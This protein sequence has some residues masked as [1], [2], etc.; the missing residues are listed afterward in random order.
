M[1]TT[2]RA[3]RR[4]D[5][6]AAHLLRAPPFRQYVLK[7]L[8]HFTADDKCKNLM[9]YHNECMGMLLHLVVG[10]PEPRV[11]RELVALVGLERLEVGN[12]AGHL[13]AVGGERVREG[14]AHEAELARALAALARSTSRG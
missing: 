2:S 5:R 10:F 11:G 9:T 3:L 12:R 4:L 7:L 14:A 8:Y 1:R 13:G 6:R